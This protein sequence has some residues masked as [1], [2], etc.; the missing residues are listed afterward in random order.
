VTIA[1]RKP[2]I[3]IG[4]IIG[5][6]I[7]FA[8]IDAIENSFEMIKIIGRQNIVAL[9]GIVIASISQPCLILLEK[10]ILRI[11]ESI[12]IPA[13]AKTERANPGS[14]AWNGSKSSNIK[15]ANPKDEIPKL[16]SPLILAANK[17]TVIT[18]ARNTEGVGLTKIIKRIKNR[19]TKKV[20]CSIFLTINWRNQKRN[21]ATNTKFAPLTA[22]R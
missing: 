5:A 4:A 15:T 7:I 11:G 17:T 18:N 22:V 10:F 13:V 14:I 12:N 6:T 20:L 8:G 9:I 16:I 2:T 1:L 21:V 3:V 19:T